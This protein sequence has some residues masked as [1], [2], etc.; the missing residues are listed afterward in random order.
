MFKKNLRTFEAEILK[1]FKNIEPQPKRLG[2]LIRRSL[3]QF[4]IISII[5]NQFR[6]VDHK[7]L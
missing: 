6:V 5:T 7:K 2:V 3:L 1:I 4:I